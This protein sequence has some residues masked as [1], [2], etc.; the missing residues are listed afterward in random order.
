VREKAK[1]NG[2]NDMR[3]AS[4]PQILNLAIVA[5]A[6]MVSLTTSAHAQDLPLEKSL[7]RAT[8]A[9]D[10]KDISDDSE[11]SKSQAAAHRF[12]VHVL[13]SDAVSAQLGWEPQANASEYVVER[14]GTEVGSTVS[15]VGRFTDFDLR[16]NHRYRYIVRAL[17]S[18]HRVTAQSKP[19]WAR[20]ADSARI[21]T[22]YKV[23]ALAFTPGGE[24]TAT[25][26]IYLRHRIQFL[27]LASQGSAT[28]ELFRN[29]IVSSAYTPVVEPGT[30]YANY[31]S[32]VT[33]R[34]L[35]GLQGYSMIDLVE[36]GE[37]DHVWIV[38]SP[39]VDFGENVLLGNRAIQGGGM[40]SANTWV[41]VPV[42][43]SRS[44]FVNAYLPDA[45]SYDAYAH[46]VEGVMTS[47]SEGHPENW[48]R[49][50]P[51]TVY[52]DH[53]NRND[54]VTEERMLNLFERFR[55]TDGWN[56]TSATAFASV[57]N[58]NCGSSH[59][60]PTTPRI[61]GYDDYTY[62]DSSGPAWHRYIDSAADDWLS[63]PIFHG[64]KRKLNGYEFGAF[65]AYKVGDPSY[66]AGFGIAPEN[67][68]SYKSTSASFHQWWFAHLPHNPGVD[69]GKLNNWW[70]YL[71]DF[72]RFTGSVIDFPTLGFPRL[73]TQF[74]P[75]DHEYGTEEHIS[76]NW[77]YWHS[78]NGASPGAKVAHLAVMNKA[79]NRR[80]VKAGRRALEVTV[81][82]GQ[83]WEGWGSGRNDVFFPKSRNAHWNRIGLAEIR[84]SMMP[85]WNVELL[86]GV[87]PIVRLCKNGSNRIEFVP[88]NNGVYANFFQDVSRRDASGW[89]DFAIPLEGSTTWEK[90]VI[91]YIDPDLPSNERMAARASLE[92]EIL[93][94]LNYIEISIRSTTSRW[95]SPDDVVSFY[96]DN[97]RLVDEPGEE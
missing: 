62:F 46:M 84:V 35:P 66:A 52:A 21:R 49:V 56:G 77:G 86:D 20:T 97:L 39:G 11:E 6:P 85:G 7:A 22:R 74:A 93:S 23:L 80:C 34:D 47:I 70:P 69:D 4:C 71:F 64:V 24:S 58:A 26:D 9:L 1:E 90:N 83:F 30:S 17:D 44:F 36:M 25:E 51:Y 16:P 68:E 40:Q 82:N 72:N 88:L 48:P 54:F 28:I 57:G 43:C 41:P 27:D 63:Y 76:A 37:I 38:R 95:E 78:E 14:D 75:V 50:Y 59:F 29:G 79:K 45:R 89:Y 73:S 12:K 87:N 32:L 91:G 19:E 31:S 67:H 18:S 60:L 92:K 15:I 61:G 94:D 8:A 3:V 33:Q 42:K 2:G 96:V 55:L 13:S 10:Q 81:E 5:F 53:G 65:N